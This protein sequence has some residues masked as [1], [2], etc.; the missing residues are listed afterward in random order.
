[1][2]KRKGDSYRL[3]KCV[4]YNLKGK[5][6][7]K[8]KTVHCKSMK[9]AKIELAK[10]VADCEKGLYIEGKSLKFEDFV[11]IWKRDYGEKEPDFFKY[12]EDKY[13]NRVKFRWNYEKN[14]EGK[15]QL[16]NFIPICECGCQLDETNQIGNSFLGTDQYVCPKCGKQYGNVLSYEEMQSFEKILISNIENGEY[17]DAKR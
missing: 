16:D 12:R 6:I 17:K 5:P 11:E 8:T 14:Y 3:V 10:F 15:Y 4:G 9:E 2:K 13:K 1:M 7:K